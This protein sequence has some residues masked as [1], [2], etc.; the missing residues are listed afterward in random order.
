MKSI[1]GERC[2]RGV[3]LTEEALLIA[4]QCDSS[5]TLRD[6]STGSASP[7]RMMGAL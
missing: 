2:A 1:R 3:L 7:S 5:A 6:G 4:S